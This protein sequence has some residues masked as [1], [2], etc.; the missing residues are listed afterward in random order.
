MEIRSRAV[1]RR[2]GAA[3]SSARTSRPGY[4]TLP[5]GCG[6]TP[7]PVATA[8]IALPACVAV[9]TAYSLPG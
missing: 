5:A 8:S 9:A 4:Q 6:W 7:A 2:H 3:V 1:S